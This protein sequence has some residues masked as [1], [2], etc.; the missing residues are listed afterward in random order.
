MIFR[1]YYQEAT[2]NSELFSIDEA[3][4]VFL[5]V[6]LTSSMVDFICHYIAQLLNFVQPIWGASPSSL[7]FT[8]LVILC[9]QHISPSWYSVTFNIIK[10]PNRTLFPILTVP[11]I[12]VGSRKHVRKREF[13]NQIFSRFYEPTLPVLIFQTLTTSYFLLLLLDQTHMYS[14]SH[15]SFCFFVPLALLREN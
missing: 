7:V 5:L 8:N 2:T 9:H 11:L 3:F 14:F 10:N 4:N 13:Q 6:S 12:L 15:A 1:T